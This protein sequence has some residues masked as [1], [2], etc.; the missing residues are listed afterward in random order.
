MNIDVQTFLVSALDGVSNHFHVPSHL[1][2]QKKKPSIS[3]CLRFWIG[4]NPG[5]D[6]LDKR[7]IPYIYQEPKPC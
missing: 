2:M 4:P 5:V 6:E 7:Y 3:D 1:P